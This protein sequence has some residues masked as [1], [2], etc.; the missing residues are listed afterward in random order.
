[1]ESEAVINE[2]NL[3]NLS[4]VKSL[5]KD[6]GRFK[7]KTVE[8]EWIVNAEDLNCIHIKTGKENKLSV[9]MK[10]KVGDSTEDRVKYLVNSVKRFIQKEDLNGESNSHLFQMREAL[11][12]FANWE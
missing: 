1:M 7:Q 6:F 9:I 5:G 11:K 12:Q 3:L 10:L 8:N 2:N 4:I